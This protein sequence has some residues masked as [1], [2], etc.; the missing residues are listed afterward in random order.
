MCKGA[1]MSF[2]S[3][4]S[5]CIIL[6]IYIDL[7]SW[8]GTFETPK[9]V[10]EAVTHS[11]AQPLTTRTWESCHSPSGSTL[12]IAYLVPQSLHFDIVGLLEAMAHRISKCAP[13]AVTC[14]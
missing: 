1:Y 7:G 3:A 10:I 5:D 14:S 12:N 11:L 13:E 2:V 9:C 8:F 6:D 4:Q